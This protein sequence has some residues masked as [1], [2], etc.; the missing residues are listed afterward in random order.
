MKRFIAVL[1][2]W[3]GAI[4]QTTVVVADDADDVKAAMLAHFAAL[5]AGEAETW[6]QHYMPEFSAFGPYGGLLSRTHSVEEQGEDIQAQF[7]E[8]LKTNL[9][10][11]HLEVKVYDNTAVVTNYLVG[12]RTLPGGITE[13]VSARR[14]SVWIKQEGQW[15]QV[16]RH[17][18]PLITALP[19]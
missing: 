4:I 6:V 12:T 16:H 3:V 2:V 10:L 15:K 17:M 18:S 1:I 9:Q 7:D 8:G 19:Q 14:S 11:R 5:N 13:Q